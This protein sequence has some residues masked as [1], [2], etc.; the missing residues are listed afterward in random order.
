VVDAPA[1]DDQAGANALNQLTPTPPFGY[2]ARGNQVANTAAPGLQTGFDAQNKLVSAYGDGQ[3]QVSLEYDA[4]DRLTT[5]QAG[6]GA[7]KQRLV[8]TP[9]Q[10]RG[11]PSTSSL[12]RSIGAAT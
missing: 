8:W 6:A 5:I 1:R 10:V 7:A 3:P 9:E 4:L 2:D 11:G 12:G